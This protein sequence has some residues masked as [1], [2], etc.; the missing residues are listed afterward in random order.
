MKK[1]KTWFFSVDEK[2]KKKK[3]VGRNFTKYKTS[4]VQKNIGRK[5]N[6]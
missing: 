3:T 5:K 1:E 2:Y 4:L 6:Q